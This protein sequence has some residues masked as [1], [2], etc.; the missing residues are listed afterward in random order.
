MKD[1]L[2]LLTL[3]LQNVCFRFIPFENDADGQT[4]HIAAGKGPSMA[5]N[6]QL[7]HQ[8]GNGCR[9]YVWKHKKWVSTAIKH[10]KN[11]S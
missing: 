5:V 2:L 11:P 8:A 7:K 3:Y 9:L 10:G 1:H 6:S 4:E